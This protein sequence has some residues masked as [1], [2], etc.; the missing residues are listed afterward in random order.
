MFYK[1]ARWL[2]PFPGNIRYEKYIATEHCN[3]FA[4]TSYVDFLLNGSASQPHN[5]TITSDDG[6]VVF[7]W[8]KNN[9]ITIPT[10]PPRIKHLLRS[11]YWMDQLGEFDD[12]RLTIE[13]SVP[14]HSDAG[15]FIAKLFYGKLD[16]TFKLSD[17]FTPEQVEFELF[18]NLS[19]RVKGGHHK[20]KFH[21]TVL[22]RHAFAQFLGTLDLSSYGARVI[23]G[24]LE[25]FKLVNPPKRRSPKIPV[26][27]TKS[28]F[29]LSEAIWNDDSH[30]KQE[31][32]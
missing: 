25:L 32:T 24:Q 18:T 28:L 27:E 17:Y 15:L 11:I 9:G 12:T 13:M 22:E 10:R 4:V 2:N 19:E 14:Y 21:L 7:K 29:P 1:I 3:E 16:K 31:P 23:Q 6:V 8:D 5:V 30:W 26:S 20:I